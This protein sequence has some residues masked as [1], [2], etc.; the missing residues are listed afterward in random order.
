MSTPDAVPPPGL[1]RTRPGNRRRLTPPG[2]A[3]LDRLAAA[4]EQSG[5]L[6]PLA[7]NLTVSHSH[8]FVWYRVAKVATRTIRHHCES[9]GVSLDVDHAMRVRYPLASYADYFTF[10]F[11]RDPLDRFVSAWHDKVVY[12]NYYDFDP[13]THDRMQ[14]VEEF[15]RWVATQDLSAVPGTDQHLTLQSRMID[16][17]RVDFVGRLETFDR[18]FAE[19]CE[20]VGAPAVPTAPRNQTA[21][22]GRDRQASDELRGLVAQMYRRDYQ[23][24][25]YPSPTDHS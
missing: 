10:A 2:E 9:H 13:A 20:R 22:G 17:N 14:V 7:Y 5:W 25:G 15:A 19:V 11:V 21:P 1:F 12:H 8:R 4:G 16:L 23:V 3:A 18:D 24:L 6:S